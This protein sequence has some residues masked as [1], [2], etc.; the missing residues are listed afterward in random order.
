MTAAATGLPVARTTT[1]AIASGVRSRKRSAEVL[2]REARDDE[3][4]IAGAAGA[5]EAVKRAAAVSTAAAAAVAALLSPWKRVYKQNHLTHM[6]WRRGVCRVQPLDIFRNQ[7]RRPR[8]SLCI[9]F[10]EEWAVSVG[11]GQAARVWDLRSGTCRMR[12]VGHQGMISTVKMDKKTIVTGGVDNLLKVWDVESQECTQ[13]LEGHEGEIVKIDYDDE[14][15]VSGSEDQ[16]LRVWRVSDGRQVRVL[17][18]HDGAVCCL[19]FRSPLVVSGSTDTTVKIWDVESGVCAATLRGHQGHVYCL[20][21]LDD[22]AAASPS[23]KRPSP[24]PTPPRPPAS[25]R[26]ATLSIITGSAD[27]TIRHWHLDAHAPHRSRHL[28]T[29]PGHHPQPVVCLQ[30]DAHKIVSGGADNSVKVW[31][32]E[33]G[34]CLYALRRHTAGVW[35]LRFTEGKLMTSSFDESLLE[36][37][38]TFVD[39][40]EEDEVVEEDGGVA[41]KTRVEGLRG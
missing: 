5:M 27:G 24:T 1:T 15:I 28:R 7:P 35:E 16:T 29:L 22:S 9:G 18:G 32:Y 13:T 14:Y 31:D 34:A 39:E 38:F 21:L 26:P 11:V 17:R 2:R 25:S 4:E 8:G 37:D 19:K 41:G 30:S 12:L 6:N 3:R 33:S 36:W 20:H 23:S 40:E 10:D